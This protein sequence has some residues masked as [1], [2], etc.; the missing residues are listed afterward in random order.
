SMVGTRETVQ[1]R[2]AE[3]LDR[4][5]VD[6]LMI[7]AQIYDHAARVRAYEIAAEVRDALGAPLTRHARA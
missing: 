1:R 3:F 6:E 2:I 7:T 5:K 4:T